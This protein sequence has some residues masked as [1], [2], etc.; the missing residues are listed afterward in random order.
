[1]TIYKNGKRIPIDWK[2]GDIGIICNY[3]FAHG[4]PSIHLRPGEE[5]ELSGVLWSSL[6]GWR[7]STIGAQTR[8][9]QKWLRFD[10][11]AGRFSERVQ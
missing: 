2:V 1:M 7:A 3:R 6:L 5:R 11:R 9:S 8:T 4:R 10:E